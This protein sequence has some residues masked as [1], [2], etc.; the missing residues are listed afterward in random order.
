VPTLKG[1]D[2]RIRTTMKLA[3]FLGAFADFDRDD[4]QRRRSGS[5]GFAPKENAHFANCSRAYLTTFFCDG[6]GLVALGPLY[7]RHQMLVVRVGT[8]RSGQ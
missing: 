2:P 7:L 6:G 8:S 1:Y 3:H 5:F 4:R